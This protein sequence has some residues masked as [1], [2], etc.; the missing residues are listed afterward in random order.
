MECSGDGLV[1]ALVEKRS[2]RVIGQAN[3]EIASREDA[4]GTFGYVVSRAFGNRGFAT[5]ASG[6]V[7]DYAFD[8]LG[9]HR[10]S[11]QIDTR[12][13]A[14][15]TVAAKL[16]L[17]REAEFRENEWFKGEW[18]S[19]WIYAILAPEWRAVRDTMVT[20]ERT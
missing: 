5:E 7:L 12:N 13:V 11:A 3:V 19:S 8:V 17:R 9:L 18:T 1:L 14:S 4:Q 20:H 16:G 6:A 2:G 10:M 15:A